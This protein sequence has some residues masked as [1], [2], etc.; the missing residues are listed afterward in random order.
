MT[1][2]THGTSQKRKKDKKKNKKRIDMA[3][4][5]WVSAAFRCD[6][7]FSK[8]VRFFV[9]GCVRVIFLMMMMMMVMMRLH[10][11][12]DIVPI[13]YGAYESV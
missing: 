11:S 2:H 8:R 3:K 10:S 1:R 6:R 4:Q 13:G 9:S 7:F 12:L 5:L